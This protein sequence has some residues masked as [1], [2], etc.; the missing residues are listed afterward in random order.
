MAAPGPGSAGQDNSFPSSLYN[1]R[2]FGAGGNGTTPDTAAIQRAVDRVSADGGGTLYFPPGDYLSGTVRLR[3]NITVFLE[4][5]CTI[6]GSTNMDDYDP[7]HKH[8]LYAENAKNITLAGRGAIDGNGPRFWD[9]GRLERWLKGEI[10]LP[11]TSDMIRFDHCENITLEDVYIRNGA[12]W[13][14]GFGYSRRIAIRALTIINGIYEEDGPNTDSVN[15]WHCTKVRISDCDIQ[16]GDDCIVVL[17]D[18]RDVS[19]TNCALTSTETALM[20]SGVRNLT[21]SNSTIHDAG[22][23]IGFRV[24]SGITVDG[25]LIDNIAMDVSKRFDTGGQAIYMWSFPLYVESE[26]EI[27]KS[28]PLPAAGTIKNVTISNVTASANG[29]VFVTGFREREGFIESLTLDNV[30]IFMYGGKEK[31]EELN[32]RPPDP[33]PIYGFHGAPYAMF[34][35]YVN[36]LK[37]RNVQFSWNSPEKSDWGS[38][39]RC[40][41]V[42]D[43]EIDGFVGRQSIQPTEPAIRLKDVDYAFVRGCRAP[44]GTGIFLELGEGTED[45]CLM[46]NDFSRA[47]KAFTVTADPAPRIFDS[48]NRLPGQ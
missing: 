18:S 4:N 7:D 46:N 40:V 29:G 13:N 47:A 31:S 48:G 19:I 1:V 21:F 43:L 20:I 12:F 16:T 6:W 28:K 38:A 27:P 39:L 2:T 22:S 41:A 5:G 24:W 34:F 8:L 9:N 17:G 30:R 45:I 42:E 10:D 33:Y 25:V 36:E 14:I 35:R 26:S 11:R 44:A 15:L 23:G 3:D 37:L 32:A